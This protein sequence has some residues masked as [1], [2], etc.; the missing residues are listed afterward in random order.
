MFEVRDGLLYNDDHEWI[1][2][3][4]NRIRFGMTD[5]AQH[6]LG[7]LV[8]VELP[9]IGRR[10]S[11]GEEIGAMESVKSV[12]PVY[13]PVSGIVVETNAVLDGA[14]E[15]VNGSPFDDGWIAVI[16]LD[17]EIPE[18]MDS[19]AYRKKTSE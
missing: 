19:E 17:G 9:E 16:E 14:P 7:D 18:M 13:S 10:V 5:Y 15:T 8:Y 4:G 3:V 1:S 6:E 11:A 2:V 12:E